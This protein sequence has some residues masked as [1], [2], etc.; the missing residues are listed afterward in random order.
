MLGLSLLTA[1]MLMHTY[2]GMLCEPP[3]H[4]CK[5][6]QLASACPSYTCMHARTHTHMHTHTSCLC[7]HAVIP[8]THTCV[9]AH[10]LS[11]SILIC[12]CTYTVCPLMLTCA[13]VC[14]QAVHVL[15]PT[16]VEKKSKWHF[17]ELPLRMSLPRLSSQ[18]RSPAYLQIFLSM[19]N[20]SFREERLPDWL[21]NTVLIFYNVDLE[22]QPA[23]QP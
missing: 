8:P 14:T 17:W 23:G 7:K 3:A 22:G 20:L 12:T 6:A 5:L 9:H 1:H 2:P 13:C 11:L 15:P 10:I 18:A 21:S 19:K 4:M 16:Q